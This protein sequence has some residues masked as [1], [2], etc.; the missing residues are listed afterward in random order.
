LRV[1]RFEGSKPINGLIPENHEHREVKANNSVRWNIVQDVQN[2]VESNQL[3]VVQVEN[4]KNMWSKG[5]AN[6]F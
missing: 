5:L 4:C 6:D 2:F 1:Q 3:Q